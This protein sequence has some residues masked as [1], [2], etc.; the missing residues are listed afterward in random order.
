MDIEVRF[1]FNKRTGEV[2]EFVV[3]AG[4]DNLPEAEHNRLHDQRTA[5]LARLLE[6]NP[7][8]TEVTSA[9]PP[10]AA[11]LT[12]RHVSNVPGGSAR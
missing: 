10:A 6:R 3:E 12:W 7:Q 2:E 4:A 11:P 1:R 8:V 9:P 5:E